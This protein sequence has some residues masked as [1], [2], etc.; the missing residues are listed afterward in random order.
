MDPRDPNREQLVKV[1]RALGDL[2][3]EVVFLGGATV[4]LLITDPAARSVRPT[5]DVDVVVEVASYAEYQ[6]KIG[7]ALRAAGF[8][9]CTDEGAPIC[10][11]RVDG[12]RVDVMPT[13]A[14][15]LGF[16]N[17]WYQQAI[18]T[19]ST[20]DIGGTT[21]RLISAPCFLATKFAAFADRGDSDYYASHDLED[22]LAVVD[23]RPSL[24][25]EI[26]AAD[27]TVRS[28][29]VQSAGRLLADSEF[30][31]ALP[32]HVDRGRD[33]VVAAR[34]LTLA[35]GSESAP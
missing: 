8:V 18:A 28:Y 5:K 27:Q 4:G 34:L 7:S 35:K 26:A 2:S 20:R 24:I 3:S 22:I 29:L 32:G 23:G 10:A 1:A 16:T 21:I 25:D 6:V 17:P 12:V 9:E 31:N 19:A 13:D 33:R 14:A 30:L 11:W 15:V